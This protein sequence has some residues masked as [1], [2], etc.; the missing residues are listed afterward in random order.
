MSL[1][2]WDDQNKTMVK[3]EQKT[4]NQHNNDGNDKMNDKDARWA[5]KR[6]LADK[7]STRLRYL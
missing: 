5:S 1:H 6:E 3:L 4:H 2:W 7:S